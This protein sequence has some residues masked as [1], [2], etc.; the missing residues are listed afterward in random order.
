M[1]MTKAVYDR[2]LLT[3]YTAIYCLLNLSSLFR[4]S[5]TDKFGHGEQV[6]QFFNWSLLQKQVLSMFVNL[7]YFT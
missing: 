1:K 6:L 5:K 7:I 3:D 4:S 2:I